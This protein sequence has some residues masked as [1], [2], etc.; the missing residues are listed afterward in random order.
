MDVGTHCV[1]RSVVGGVRTEARR[2]TV[3]LKLNGTCRLN[4][5]AG[6][7]D[8]G[9]VAT[10]ALPEDV[11]AE[12][13][14]LGTMMLNPG[15]IGDVCKIIPLDDVRWFNDKRHQAV[16]CALLD[17]AQAGC[18]VDIITLR[19]QLE[20]EEALNDAGGRDYLI[21]LAETA[22][23]AVNG[24]TYAQRVREAG[25]R[26]DLIWLGFKL[27]GLARDPG[28]SA[29]ELLERA[30]RLALTITARRGDD[31][32]RGPALV[33]LDDIEAR[34]VDWL[35]PGRIP[36]GK[37]SMIVGDPGLGKTL[38][39]CDMAAR[40]S[41]G[42]DWP[43]C[44]NPNGAVG[45]VMLNAEDDLADTVKPR[46]LAAGADC[47]RIVA[48]QGR[49]IHTANG[50]RVAP[51]T[52]ADLD[53]LEAAIDRSPDCRLV[54][55][56]PITAFC[57]KVDSH[58]NAEVRGLLAPLADLAARRGVAVVC[59]SHLRKGGDGPA[60]HK[61]MGSL[62]F[63]AAVRTAWAV[64][65]DKNDVAD[66]RR[67]LLLIKNNLAA[68]GDGLAFALAP[69]DGAAPFVAWEGLPIRV[70]VDDAL[71]PRRSKPGPDPEEREAA[72]A[73]LRTALVDGP[74]PTRELIDEARQKDGISE[75]TLNRAKKEIGVKSYKPEN[76][77]P[78]WWRL[79]EGTTL[80]APKEPGN[81]AICPGATENADADSLFGEEGG[82]IATLPG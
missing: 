63:V 53:I 1:R 17:L 20:N 56:D 51:M 3:A 42:R 70:N 31:P 25:L 11:E 10:P 80:P 52:L 35:W 81:L 77:G 37:L 60:I 26:R 62:A 79:P 8:G 64:A 58:V 19:G 2:P 5:H 72:K 39:T 18:K 27:D 71:A 9:F 57:G 40:A 24:P 75:T 36:L 34:A 14:T 68:D 33:N 16:Y 69:T 32:E 47:S 44:D 22:P 12:R 21:E 59:V 13:A 6:W 55:V 78:W 15:C 74:R 43:D 48:L 7:I 67:L 46:L 54:V 61:T 45:V 29:G 65:K 41:I 50:P 4:D 76:P 28:E 66:K 30:E 38:V 23:D 49:R 82:H 73:W